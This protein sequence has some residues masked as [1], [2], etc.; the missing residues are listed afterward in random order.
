MWK[1]K[2][3]GAF[4]LN[5]RVD[6]H[7]IDATPARWRGDAVPSPLDGAS[8]ATSSP[9]NDLVKNRRRTR[10]TGWFPHRFRRASR[11]PRRYQTPRAWHSKVAVLPQLFREGPRPQLHARTRWEWSAYV[12]AQRCIKP[13]HRPTTAGSPDGSPAKARP[14]DPP[15]PIQRRDDLRFPSDRYEATHDNIFRQE[16]LQPV[17]CCS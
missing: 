17:P 7:A 12:R 8:A 15:P 3:Y 4:V 9:R 5:R 11:S 1:S 6:L 13:R 16:A 14:A 2:F 10:R